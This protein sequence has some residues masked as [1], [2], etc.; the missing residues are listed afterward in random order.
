MIIMLLGAREAYQEKESKAKE[1]E[2]KKWV[3][4][5]KT[6]LLTIINRNEASIWWDDSAYR[7]IR[8]PNM[9]ELEINSDQK[10]IFLNQTTI[11]AEVSQYVYDRLKDCNAVR[12]YYMPESPMT[13][14]L[15][16]EL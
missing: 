6:A 12:I 1:V 7:P 15:E 11:Q 4:N 5:C 3:K 9:L 14:F 2:K 10:G 13:F 8:S 16:E